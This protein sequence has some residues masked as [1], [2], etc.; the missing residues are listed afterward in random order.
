MAKRKR[1]MTLFDVINTGQP[2]GLQYRPRVPTHLPTPELPV[3][4]KLAKLFGLKSAQQPDRPLTAAE[5]LERMRRELTGDPVEAVADTQPAAQVYAQTS[6][7]RRHV[8]DETQAFESTEVPAHDPTS[9]YSRPSRSRVADLAA[10]AEAAEEAEVAPRAPRKPLSQSA[11]EIWQTIEPKLAA[12]GA[13]TA[14]FIKTS[15]K[16]SAGAGQLGWT[17]LRELGVRYGVTAGVAMGVVVLLCGSFYAGKL[18]LNRPSIPLPGTDLADSNLRPDVIALDSGVRANEPI[19]NLSES[20]TEARLERGADNTAP[21][22]T[23]PFGG[24]SLDLN[25]VIVQ[26]YRT[27]AEAQATVD[28]LNRHG[29]RT[30]VEQDLRGYQ[31]WF[32]V[33]S[34]D[35][36]NKPSTNEV[37]RRFLDA[38]NQI[39]DKERGTT[40][41]MRLDPRPYRH[42]A[43]S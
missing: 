2:I 10:A 32:S 43:A 27:R 7:E 38:I 35:G 26:S 18:L 41:T 16:R 19:A 8:E 31:G 6:S 20:K 4:R 5:E 39:S 36:F 34:V 1:K 30:T 15:S 22:P 13:G 25:Y 42:Q 37:Y 9:T 29:I 11:R 24:R 40:L 12:V 21:T 14:R 33:V 17:H 23:G 3:K 28:V